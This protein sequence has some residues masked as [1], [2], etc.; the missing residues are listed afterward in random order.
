MMANSVVPLPLAA[1]GR[2]RGRRLNAADGYWQPNGYPIIKGFLKIEEQLPTEILAGRG[3]TLRWKFSAMATWAATSTPF[4]NRSTAPI[5]NPQWSG[6]KAVMEAGSR[7][8]H[9]LRSDERRHARSNW[10]IRTV[11]R[12]RLRPRHGTFTALNTLRLRHLGNCPRSASIRSDSTGTCSRQ[13]I[14]HSLSHRTRKTTGSHKL[15]HECHG[16]PS[17]RRRSQHRQTSVTGNRWTV[18]SATDRLL[19][20]HVVRHA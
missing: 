4:R 9:Y 8:K 14:F 19:A 10:T 3:K 16:R 2:K 5:L 18:D 7:A 12:S 17:L 20:Q 11:R 13:S 15:A 6:T 1:S